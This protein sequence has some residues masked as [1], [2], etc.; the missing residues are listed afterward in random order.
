MYGI[1]KHFGRKGLFTRTNVL[2]FTILIVKVPVTKDT[3]LNFDGHCNGDGN[4]TCKQ[5]F[6]GR[7]RDANWTYC[8][9]FGH[10]KATSQKI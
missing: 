4:G 8:H 7:I 2:P 3:M 1:F 9:I 6:K 5:A 10:K